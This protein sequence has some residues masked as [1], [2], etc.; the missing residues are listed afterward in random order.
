MSS[1]Y[2]PNEALVE[3]RLAHTVGLAM[4]VDFEFVSVAVLGQ[5]VVLQGT[6]PS[7]VAKARATES[8]R[9]AGY[10]EIDNRLRVIPGLPAA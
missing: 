3:R 5:R 8:V 7:Y 2:K 6:A 10:G 1:V 4:G 9:Q